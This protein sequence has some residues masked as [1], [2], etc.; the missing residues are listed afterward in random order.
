MVVVGT[1]GR[2]PVKSLVLGSV[3]ATVAAHARCPVA[4]AREVKSDDEAPRAVIAAVDDSPTTDEVLALAY[5]LAECQGR[6][7]EVVHCW[8]MGGHVSGKGTYS[9]WLRELSDREQML[10]DAMAL[11]TE[12]HPDVR[13]SRHLTEDDPV[14][15]LVDRSGDAAVLVVGSRGRSWHGR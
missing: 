14:W 12:K 6:P 3:S 5:E 9:A 15:T 4:V 11:Q 7:L 8:Q 10:D 2:G 1:G 13:A